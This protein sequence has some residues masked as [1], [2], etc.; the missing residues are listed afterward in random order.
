MTQHITTKELIDNARDYYERRKLFAQNSVGLERIVYITPEGYRCAIGASLT[1]DSLQAIKSS[2]IQ[3]CNIVALLMAKIVSFESEG[4]A[5]TL[6]EL[7]DLWAAH[8]PGHEKQDKENFL[9]LL[10]ITS[11]NNS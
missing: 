2:K 6:Q 9:F 7:H 4:F 3:N 10:N 1:D 8:R 11:E 5:A